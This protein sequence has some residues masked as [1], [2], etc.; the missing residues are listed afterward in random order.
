MAEKLN[1]GIVGCGFIGSALKNW[2]RKNNKNCNIFISDPP[3]GLD[4]DLSAC[5]AIFVSVHLPT[6]EDGAQN[7]DLVEKIIQ[8]LPRVPVF[9]R[10]TV[11]PGTC[12]ALSKKFCREIYFMP[13]F[14]TQRTAQED[15]DRQTMVFTG[16]IELLKRIFKHKKY[17]EMTS[18]EAEIAKYAHNVFGA[19]K[20]TYF[21]GI[22]DICKKSGC[23]YEKVLDGML[24]SGYINDCHT[25]VPGPDGL[26]GYGG[27]CFP[28]DVRAFCEF[29]R[30]Y[31]VYG[32][33]NNLEKLNGHFR[34]ETEAQ[35]ES[36]I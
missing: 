26:L 10:T 4:D 6:E 34:K 35:I 14:L 16:Q 20:V 32:L 21:N 33:I 7:L 3:K 36:F 11:L 8:N 17:I 27:K 19:L 23:S 22:Y 15:F 28:K 12:D 25:A 18:Y 9:V 13:E 2:L 5:D 30:K 29:C 1:I 31:P 24:L